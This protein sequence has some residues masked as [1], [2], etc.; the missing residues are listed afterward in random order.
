MIYTKSIKVL[1]ETI[2]KL[3]KLTDL[4]VFLKNTKIIKNFKSD[5]AAIGKSHCS[6]INFTI[7]L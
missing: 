3:T 4:K 2:G 7:K 6:L 1:H 5:L